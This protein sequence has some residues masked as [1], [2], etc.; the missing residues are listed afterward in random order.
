MPAPKVSRVLLPSIV[1]LFWKTRLGLELVSPMTTLELGTPIDT[2]L[3]P[4]SC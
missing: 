4:T 3:N 1:A 2:C